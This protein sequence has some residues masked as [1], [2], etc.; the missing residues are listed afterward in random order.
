VWISILQFQT[1][2]VSASK[3]LYSIYT[4]NPLEEN[5]LGN[6]TSNKTMAAHL[7]RK[8]SL[9]DLALVNLQLVDGKLPTSQIF[10]SYSAI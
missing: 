3:I 10:Y 2:E 5:Q 6:P 8:K 4:Q 1:T 9:W 7:A